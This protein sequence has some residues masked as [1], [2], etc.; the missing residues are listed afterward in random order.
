MTSVAVAAAEV[1]LGLHWTCSDHGDDLRC[2]GKLS[3]AA[4]SRHPRQRQW[5]RPQHSPEVH[6]PPT[7]A[8]A[9]PLLT[10]LS[11]SP[12]LSLFH[13]KLRKSNRLGPNYGNNN[14]GGSGQSGAT[15]CDHHPANDYSCNDEDGGHN[16]DDCKGRGDAVTAVGQ[17]S[18]N[19]HVPPTTTT[20]PTTTRQRWWRREVGDRSPKSPAPPYDHHHVGDDNGCDNDNGN[21]ATTTTATMRQQR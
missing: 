15:D 5:A 19:L 18:P 12:A 11:S 6:N 8:A 2:G 17:R 16:S 20:T 14:N 3:S 21:D 1:V 10:E 13:F 9:K 7:T 4:S